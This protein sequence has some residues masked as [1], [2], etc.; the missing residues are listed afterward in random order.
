MAWGVCGVLAGSA[1]WDGISVC[2]VYG[3]GRATCMDERRKR[4]EKQGDPLIE[5]YLSGLA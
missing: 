1:C 4:K 3:E 2:H 5:L